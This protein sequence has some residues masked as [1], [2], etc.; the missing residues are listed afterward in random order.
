[1]SFQASLSL[2]ALG[3]TLYFQA[4]C[5]D[6]KKIDG[7]NGDF[8]WSSTG[9]KVELKSDY[10]KMEKTPNFFIERYSDKEKKTPGGPWRALQDGST[11]FVY[12]YIQNLT[13]FTFRCEEL[14]AFLTEQMLKEKCTPCDVVN[15]SWTTLGYRVPRTAVEHLATKE[16]LTVKKSKKGPK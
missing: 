7:M 16:Y 15:K 4:N 2:G 9:E 10:Y 11:I 6:L 12:F 8:I 1:M 3:E 13:Y 14:C 5:G